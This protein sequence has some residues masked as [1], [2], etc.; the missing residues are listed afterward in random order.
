MLRILAELFD[1]GMMFYERI[2]LLENMGLRFL[3]F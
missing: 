2:C 3:E 1:T